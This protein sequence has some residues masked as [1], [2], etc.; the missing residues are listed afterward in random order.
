MAETELRKRPAAKATTV[1]GQ[2]ESAKPE[3]EKPVAQFAD[4]T[5]LQAKKKIPKKKNSFNVVPYIALLLTI[6]SV[7]TRVYRLGRADFVVW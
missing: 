2:P 7:F 1:N 4:D 6:A 5:D 3:S